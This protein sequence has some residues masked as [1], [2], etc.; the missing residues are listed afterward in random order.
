MLLRDVLKGLDY[1][2]INVQT[3]VEIDF[4][5]DCS[6]NIEENTLFIAICGDKYNGND[7]I[8]ES[9]EK[10]AKA[11]LTD[12]DLSLDIP[13]IKVSDVRKAKAK[14]ASNFYKNPSN[15]MFIIGVTGTNEKQQQH[16]S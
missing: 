14:I 2:E 10:G 12:I 9:I 13:F 7:F 5:S 6:K 8:L 4:I 16:I 11:I 15:S 1:L 3:N